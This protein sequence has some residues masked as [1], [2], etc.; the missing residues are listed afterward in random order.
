MNSIDID[1]GGTFTDLVLNFN[2]KALIKKVPTTPYDLSVCFSRVIE[3]G[4]GALGLKIEELLPAVDMIRYSTTIA[5]NRLI[6]RKGPRLALIT[7]E[8]HEDVVL[9]GRGAQWIDGTRVAERRNLAVQKKPD[10]LIPREM[11]V[12]VKERVDS[13]GNVIRPLDENDVR[14]KVRYLVNRGARGFVVSLLWGFLNPIHERRIKEVIRD[15]YKEFHIGYMP[16]VLAGQVVGKLGE[17]ERTL[18]AILDAYLQ[19]SMQIELSAMWDKLRERGYKKP[20]LMIQSSGGIAEVFR[21]SA[22][23][24]FNSGPV[25][26]LMGA[27]HVAKS[28]GYQNVVM[29]DMGGTSFDVGLVVKDSVR[30]YDFRPII[31]RW[32]VGITMIKTL[33]VGAGGGSIASLNRLLQ[34]RLQV[35]PRSAGSMPGPACFN[36]GGTEPTVTDADVVL[37]YINPEYYY[38]GKMRLDRNRSIQAIRDKIAKPM[39]ISVEEAA[40]I[41][42][43]IVNGNMSSAIMKEVHLRGY[44]PEEFILFVGGGAG[45]THAEGFK[46]DIPKAVMFP[47]SPVFCAYGSSTMDIMHVYEVSKKITLMTP[48]D[49]QLTQDY[50]AFNTTVEALLAQARK[51]LVGDGMDPQKATFVLELDM[52]YGGQFHVKR[53]LSPRLA[54]KSGQDVRTL[55]DAFNKE[56][57]EAFSP[58]VV[59]PEGGIFIESFILKAI[60]TTPKVHLPKMP[61]EKSDPSAARKGER[62]AYWPDAGDFRTTPIFAYESLRPGNVVEGP[63]IVEGEYTTMV[64]PPLMR[65]SI[66]ERGLGILEE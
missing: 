21:T 51:D 39:G 49:Q 48:G 22:S 11:I 23:R 59:N 58:F 20:L 61:L 17:Y 64:V 42:R 13:R 12:G 32:M 60:V 5:M 18:A 8:G 63:A 41:I 25:S 54:L 55:C 16:V 31:D 43:K 3:E 45:P 33:S 30:S 50:D 14:E 24:T 57:S 38:G 9:I 62:P 4:A 27:H 26:G 65:F 46:G 15:E 6:E 36:L 28:L 52:L 34:N 47:F 40:G 10:P 35:G 66:D 19:R 53:A 56:F 7:T 37:G 1:V 29:T 44:S 2:D